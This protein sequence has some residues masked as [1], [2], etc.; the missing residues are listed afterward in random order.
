MSGKRYNRPIS[1]QYEVSAS[2]NSN[3]AVDWIVSDGVFIDFSSQTNKS[4][5]EHDEF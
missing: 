4:N 5:H 2:S 3:N 1:G